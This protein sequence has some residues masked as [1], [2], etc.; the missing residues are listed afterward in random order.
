MREKTIVLKMTTVVV[1]VIAA[2][3]VDRPADAA[4]TDADT[5]NRDLAS[6]PR[7][8]RLDLENLPRH[9]LY[10]S[11]HYNNRRVLTL[12]GADELPNYVD[13]TK[14]APDQDKVPD[15]PYGDTVAGYNLP[16]SF[17]PAP[18][19]A[20]PTL[21]SAVMKQA[22]QANFRYPLATTVPPETNNLLSATVLPE[23]NEISPFALFPP[24][25]H[26]LL[27]IPLHTY[28]NGSTFSPHHRYRPV[29]PLIS[30]G[31]ASTKI[32]GNANNV[33]APAN[34]DT[35]VANNS[36]EEK[37]I[38][39]SQT[40]ASTTVS[41]QNSYHP[42]DPPT[43]PSSPS[44]SPTA[45][46]THTQP[47]I[48]NDRYQPTTPPY[49]SR[50][51]SPSFR[52]FINVPNLSHPKPYPTHASTDPKLAYID[53]HEKPSPPASIPP[54]RYT[55]RP[56]EDNR[57]TRRPT[58]DTRITHSPT[59]SIRTTPH[60]TTT[61]QPTT[62]PFHTTQPSTTQ[63]DNLWHH[64]FGITR[65]PLHEKPVRIPTYGTRI[66]SNPQLHS[67]R[68]EEEIP[69]VEKPRPNISTQS[70][71]SLIDKQKE[72]Q[73]FRPS[74][75][76][77]YLPSGREPSNFTSLVN[78]NDSDHFATG[79]PQSIPP[80]VNTFSLPSRRP[81]PLPTLNTESTNTPAP[82]LSSLP[83][84]PSRPFLPPPPPPPFANRPSIPPRRP[85]SPHQPPSAPTVFLPPPPPPSVPAAFLPPPPSFSEQPSGLPRHERPAQDLS[86]LK[87]PQFTLRPPALF[88]GL[89][90]RFNPPPPQPTLRQSR[91][92]E[93]GFTAMENLSKVHPP[94]QIVP[95][96]GTLAPHP[97]DVADHPEPGFNLPAEAGNLPKRRVQDENLIRPQPNVLPQFRPNAPPQQE[98]FSFQGPSASVFNTSPRPLRPD[99]RPVLS[100]RPSFLENFNFFGRE[101]VNRRGDETGSLLNNNSAGDK[102]YTN[103]KTDTVGVQYQLTQGPIP[104]HAQ[105]V[106]V[107]GPFK[108]PPLGAP[109]INLPNEDLPPPVTFRDASF[110]PPPPP[111]LPSLS[112]SPPLTKIPAAETSHNTPIAMPVEEVKT[113]PL[114]AVNRISPPLLPTPQALVNA[115]PT[116]WPHASEDITTKEDK[117]LPLVIYGRPMDSAISTLHEDKIP[118]DVSL[119]L[120]VR[121]ENVNNSASASHVVPVSGVIE[122]VSDEHKEGIIAAKIRFP[123]MHGVEKVGGDI[124]EQFPSGIIP[125]PVPIYPHPET[126]TQSYSDVFWSFLGFGTSKP[127][128]IAADR[129]S[130]LPIQRGTHKRK[131]NKSRSPRPRPTP[132]S[133]QRSAKVDTKPPSLHSPL[134][135]YVSIPRPVPFS[136]P[137]ISPRLPVITT[138]STTTETQSPLT[139][140]LPSSPTPTH[141]H[142]LPSRSSDPTELRPIY[143]HISTTSQYLLT[144][145]P[146]EIAIAQSTPKTATPLYLTEYSSHYSHIPNA[147]K[148]HEHIKANTVESSS[149][150]GWKA[151]EVPPKPAE[152]S[153]ASLN[154]AVAYIRENTPDVIIKGP[155]TDR[156]EQI[157]TG[158]ISDRMGEVDDQM[159]Q[160]SSKLSVETPGTVRSYWVKPPALV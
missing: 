90:P 150:G 67:T 124:N 120:K 101:N 47:T 130:V 64:T 118:T 44:M 72:V 20:D 23:D 51:T 48:Q 155:A 88:S 149:Y 102:V 151:V 152:E 114:E 9:P 143:R 103:K 80:V 145:Q 126:T 131:R 13:D 76:D 141:L 27:E 109:I 107:V 63:P 22:D 136:G 32:Q 77:P 19:Y 6:R 86:K 157:A 71:P 91:P 93:L 25:F 89:S 3:L 125:V 95:A 4:T 87:E 132:R 84:P 128:P 105:K 38:E 74:K 69:P 45:H 50:P 153:R 62:T 21:L 104:E 33:I 17:P 79:S 156:G 1:I 99:R 30:K 137:Q 7:Q 97:Q 94:F 92:H 15:D 106:M 59:K 98:T 111:P 55:R 29:G 26:G 160:F 12:G 58:E 110:L 140:T 82:P 42:T 75:A 139:L 127:E 24:Q 121:E 43:T 159:V 85:S 147:P 68:A 113:Y 119:S 133:Q 108:Q 34:Q 135:S 16:D 54:L 11:I 123:P 112:I 117:K 144:T 56:S 148:E 96:T 57:A 60:I 52:P 10:H 35:Q 36:N 100:K 154:P 49:H 83:H 41:S 138:S 5:I 134:Q 70:K 116:I 8:G 73:P 65:R 142:Q 146:T 78:E 158:V 28:S 14:D 46:T 115:P 39:R 66:P 61:F 53:S 2:V 40:T 18:S 81:H 37:P 129:R 31:Y 122:E